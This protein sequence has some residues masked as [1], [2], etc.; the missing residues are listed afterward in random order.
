[1]AKWTTVGVVF[2]ALGVFASCCPLPLA[3]C[4]LAL[5]A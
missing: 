4:L 5:S 2:A 1:M 3:E